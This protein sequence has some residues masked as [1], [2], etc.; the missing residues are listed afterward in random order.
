MK[1]DNQLLLSADIA[2]WGVVS[3]EHGSLLEATSPEILDIY[4]K[5]MQ[6]DG[7]SCYYC[8]FTCDK[9]QEVHHIDHNHNNN[10]MSN[11]VTVCPLCH[12]SHH[13]SL[14]DLHNGASLIWC[15]ELTQ[16]EINDFCRIAFILNQINESSGKTEGHYIS[17]MG[18]SS[19][20][21]KLLERGIQSMETFFEGG[22]NC[23]TFG[24]ILLDIKNRE[25]EL[26]MQREKWLGNIK[27]LHKPMRFHIQTA[28]WR[29]IMASIEGF[30]IDKWVDYTIYKD[31]QGEPAYTPPTAEQVKKEFEL[32]LSLLR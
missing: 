23:G 22:S 4:R 2:A 24:Q 15:P 31:K 14:A 5:V 17:R 16:Q 32:D 21:I 9:Y 3:Q 13:L 29:K 18:F 25:P 8:G 10:D 6:R 1:L 20:Y 19:I 12:Q 27:M 11:L 30:R 7:G 28:Y 26:Y